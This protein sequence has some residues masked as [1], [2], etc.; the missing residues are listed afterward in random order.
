MSS[1]V[2]PYGLKPARLL[3]PWDF[4]GVNT[5]VCGY[6][7]L[8]GVFPPQVSN[9]HLLGLLEWQAGSLLLAPPGKPQLSY[10][11]EQTV[12]TCTSG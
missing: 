3:C 2:R 11:R 5:A 7:L 9:P 8:Q 12:D 4:L 6:V 10:K 1:P